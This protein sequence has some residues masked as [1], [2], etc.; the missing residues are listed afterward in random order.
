MHKR[1]NIRCLF[2][3]IFLFVAIP[4]ICG[5]TASAEA[6]ESGKQRVSTLVNESTNK[7]EV[8]DLATTTITGCSTYVR[9]AV[10]T[11]Y[12]NKGYSVTSN[13]SSDSNSS[14]YWGNYYTFKCS[15]DEAKFPGYRLVMATYIGN[16]STQNQGLCNSGSMCTTQIYSKIALNTD[17]VAGCN[18]A[19][20]QAVE[21]YYESKG[22]YVVSN[23]RLVVWNRKPA[24]L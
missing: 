20:R 23:N 24:G 15:N 5:F 3:V 8:T 13:S 4:M 21:D 6:T 12:K 7:Q 18:Y 11:Y 9:K 1:K 2:A 16:A 22:V 14:T 10:E 17:A 19:V